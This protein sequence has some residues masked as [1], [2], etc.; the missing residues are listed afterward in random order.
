MN[1]AVVV[2]SPAARWLAEYQESFTFLVSHRR[3]WE[4]HSQVLQRRPRYTG[5]GGRAELT[6]EGRL[7]INGAWSEADLIV[8]QSWIERVLGERP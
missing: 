3:T 6:N 5:P 1:T 2:E 8:L 7:Q 4:R